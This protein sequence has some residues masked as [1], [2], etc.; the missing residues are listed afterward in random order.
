MQTKR[1][2]LKTMMDML[3][4]WTKP[5]SDEIAGFTQLRILH[6]GNK[7][8]SVYI[9]EVRRVV[10]LC[11]LGCLGDCKDRLIRRYIVAGLNSTKVY[12][13][14]ISKVSSL[15]LNEYIKICQV[16]DATCMQVQ[17]LHPRSSDCMDSTPVHKIAL[18]SQQQ[19]RHSFRG[20]GPY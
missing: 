3:E 19:V 10:D 1:D 9:Q 18:Y 7:T 8:L 15:T 11:N 4:D 20:R 12:Q 17:T 2:S 6:Q 5:K 16:E 14:C 13:Q